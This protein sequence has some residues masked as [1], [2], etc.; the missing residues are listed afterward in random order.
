MERQ[1]RMNSAR[2]GKRSGQQ[3]GND[4][5]LELSLLFAADLAGL[6]LLDLGNFFGQRIIDD[7]GRQQLLILAR[8]EHDEVT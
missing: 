4:I 3:R 8:A 1:I 5:I 2:A 6:L 7:G